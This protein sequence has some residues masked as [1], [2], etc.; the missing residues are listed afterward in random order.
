MRKVL[1]LL[2]A[3]LA[4]CGAREPEMTAD[5]QAELL[6][7]DP[8]SVSITDAGRVIGIMDVKMVVEASNG[9][10]A[11]LD[12][13]MPQ[14]RD[15]ARTALAEYGRLYATPWQAVDA[16]ELADALNKAMKAVAPATGEVLIT[17]LRARKA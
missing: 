3:A 15:A 1:T 17:E 14:L 10:A 6:T 4:L 16:Q 13:T 5:R 2:P 8:V 9:D 7:L 11:A 12:A